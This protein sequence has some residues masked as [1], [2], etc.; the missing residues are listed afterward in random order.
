MNVEALEAL[1]QDV[2]KAFAERF[3]EVAEGRVSSSVFLHSPET[4]ERESPCVSFK[5]FLHLSA[6]MHLP[7]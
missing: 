4:R 6:G 7:S 2:L 3:G 1:L 5:T